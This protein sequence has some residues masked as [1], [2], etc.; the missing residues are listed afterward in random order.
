MELCRL[1][2]YSSLIA[3]RMTIHNPELQQVANAYNHF[4]VRYIR[5][6]LAD[7]VCNQESLHL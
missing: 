4:L 7:F 2:V 6:F 1:A 3:Y 5:Q